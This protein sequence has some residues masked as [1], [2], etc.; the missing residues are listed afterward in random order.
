[1]FR[2]SRAYLQEDTVVYM[3]HMA[4]S[5]STGVL[6]QAVYRQATTN[7]R[8]VTLLYAACIQLYPPED[9]HFRFE[10]YRGI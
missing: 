2:A 5:L 6:T 10:T 1:M 7:S 4:R 3:R 9:E 8:R